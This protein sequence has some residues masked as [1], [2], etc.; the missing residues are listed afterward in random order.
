MIYLFSVC[1]CISVYTCVHVPPM[2]IKIWR[3]HQIYR[4]GV[5]DIGLLYR[6][7][8]LTSQSSWFSSK[9]TCPPIHLT[10]S[11]CHFL[12]YLVVSDPCPFPLLLTFFLYTSTS[13]LFPYSPIIFI[14]VLNLKYTIYKWK[15]LCGN[16]T[17]TFESRIL[18]LL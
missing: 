3:G 12:T 1:V 10:S 15:K 7:N 2:C 9:H 14:A 5:T 11:L 13:L 4:A 8:N 16:C 18:G 6:C 17:F